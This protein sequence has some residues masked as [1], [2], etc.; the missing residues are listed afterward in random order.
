MRTA[1][2]RPQNLALLVVTDICKATK[3][4]FYLN[5]VLGIIV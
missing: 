4:D 5:L 3:Q 2:G 1:H